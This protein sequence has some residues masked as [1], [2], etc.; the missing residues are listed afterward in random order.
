MSN[1]LNPNTT[2]FVNHLSVANSLFDLG[3][4]C[5]KITYNKG[6]HRVYFEKTPELE[7]AIEVVQRLHNM[8]VQEVQRRKEQQKPVETVNTVSVDVE[9]ASVEC[10]LDEDLCLPS[11]IDL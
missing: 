6:K 8:Y 5:S 9:T 3:F 11:G 1:A 4:H 7:R 2:V 10:I